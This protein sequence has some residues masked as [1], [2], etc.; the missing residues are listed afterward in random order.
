MCQLL[1]YSSFYC[2]WPTLIT[3]ISDVSSWASRKASIDF[4]DLHLII[5]CLGS[6][7]LQ[8]SGIWPPGIIHPPSIQGTLL[9]SPLS[10]HS[11]RRGLCSVRDWGWDHTDW[12]MAPSSRSLIGDCILRFIS[13]RVWDLASTV[14]HF[15][16]ACN[17][18]VDDALYHDVKVMDTLFCRHKHK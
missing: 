4:P 7:L 13:W 3:V 17:C 10:S 6:C 12:I 16:H 15:P 9:Q 18:P 8:W 14:L 5:S 1:I 11:K 2:A